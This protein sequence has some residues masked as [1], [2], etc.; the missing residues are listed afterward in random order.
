VGLSIWERKK[1]EKSF[2]CEQYFISH[3][4]VSFALHKAWIWSSCN[5]EQQWPANKYYDVR[6][7]RSP[8]SLKNLVAYRAA[9]KS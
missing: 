2:V 1:N 3:I 6:M 7:E 4:C 9:K 8:F 5:G